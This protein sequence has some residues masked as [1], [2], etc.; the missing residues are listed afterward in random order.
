MYYKLK[1]LTF[2]SNFLPGIYGCSETNF[3]KADPKT[4]S[5]RKVVDDIKKVE[6]H[7]CVFLS[8]NAWHLLSRGRLQLL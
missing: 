1:I 2:C 3:H 4:K 7:W 6:K 8:S 5:R